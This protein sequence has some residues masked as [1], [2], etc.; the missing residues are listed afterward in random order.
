VVCADLARDSTYILPPFYAE[1]C[2]VSTLDVIIRNKDGQPWGVLEIDNPKRHI[3]DEHDINFVTGFANV[4][5]EAVNSSKRNEV[6]QAGVTPDARNG[7]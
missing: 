6:V 7:R 4:L 3:Y 1:H 5:A 2:I